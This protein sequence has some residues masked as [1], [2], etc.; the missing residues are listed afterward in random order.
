MDVDCSLEYARDR[1][2]ELRKDYFRYLVKAMH[3]NG[4]RIN[5]N[6]IKEKNIIPL[7]SN[8][9]SQIVF[10][11]LKEVKLDFPHFLGFCLES[12]FVCK[13]NE[14]QDIFKEVFRIATKNPRASINNYN[15]YT[16]IGTGFYTTKNSFK[17][18]YSGSDKNDVIFLSYNSKKGTLNPKLMS[19]N[20]G[21]AGIQIKSITSNEKEKIIK[22][23]IT[24]D[25]QNVITL[26]KNKDTGFQ[27]KKQC[28]DIIKEFKVDSKLEINGR[29]YNINKEE[30]N[31]LKQFIF[32]PEDVGI[33]Q[34][35]IDDFC[36]YVHFTYEQSKKHILSNYD[37]YI[38][39]G[40][41]SIGY[42][43]NYYNI[44]P[45]IKLC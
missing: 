39:I 10:D 25:Y 6:A 30:R 37:K 8:D 42:F 14:N 12:F 26:L 29:I 17:R 19:D 27:S 4:E 43:F 16:A 36:E 23:L 18:Y 15:K 38:S 34:Q 24:G 32:S 13:C 9:T 22:P 20:S 3:E 1:Y 44:E 33:S 11:I 35:E 2:K 7:Y 5:K 41:Q 28:L 21:Y 31:Y 40:I 45:T